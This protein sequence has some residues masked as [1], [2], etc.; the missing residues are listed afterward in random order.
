[1]HHDGTEVL[2]RLSHCQATTRVTPMPRC[3]LCKR[4]VPETTEHHLTPRTRHRKA[5][6]QD[7]VDPEDL[8]ET[9]SL[10][11]TCHKQIHIRF[12]NRELAETYNDL[13]KLRKDPELGRY[14]RW[15]AKQKPQRRLPA[16]RPA[17]KRHS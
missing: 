2:S 10:C 6:E 4:N 5:A 13:D 7:D 17:R 16:R 1:M 12:T 14:I 15:A 3:T 9:V 8:E 11:P